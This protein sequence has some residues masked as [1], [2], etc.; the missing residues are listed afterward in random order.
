MIMG[1]KKKEILWDIPD[2]TTQND[3]NK[4]ACIATNRAT[5]NLWRINMSSARNQKLHLRDGEPS[6]HAGPE[7]RSTIC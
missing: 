5:N 3:K 7:Q 6:E 2:H 1:K 4:Q